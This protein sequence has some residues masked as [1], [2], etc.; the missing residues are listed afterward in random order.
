MLGMLVMLVMLAMDDRDV[1]GPCLE[2]NLIASW[3]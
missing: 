3:L 2:T 1:N